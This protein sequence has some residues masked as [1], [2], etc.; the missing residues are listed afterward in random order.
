MLLTSQ[1]I[2]LFAAAVVLC[3]YHAKG[4]TVPAPLAAAP[5]VTL[6]RVF[7]DNMV[8]QEG[9]S[10]PIWGWGQDGDTVTVQFQ[11]ETVSTRV[12]DG[13]WL[14]RLGGLKASGPEILT[15]TT[16]AFSN[17]PAI[18]LTNVLVGEVWLASGQSNMEFPLKSSFAAEGDI[19]KSANPMIHLLHVP[20][21]RL[22]WPTNDISASWT[23]CNPK[24]APDFSAV[25]YY[26]ARD[27]QMALNVPIGVIEAD[28]GATPAEVW[29]QR[30]FL[31]ANPRYKDEVFG[32]WVVAE[33]NYERS[34]A[35]Y[36]K[37]K[38]E[39]K[40]KGMEF[41]NAVPSRPWEP[42]ELF[43]GMIAPLVGYAIKGALWYQGESNAG[44]AE[45]AW[46]YHTLF[47]D[48]IRNWRE[49]WG[50]G[51]FPFLLVQ[52]APFRPIQ[53]AP[54]ESS[55]ASVREAQLR[56]TEVLPNVGMAVI[57]DFGDQHN[58]HP[59]QKEPVGARLAL[60]A[61]GIAYHE[62]IEYS[63]PVLKRVKIEETQIVLTF[64]HVDGGLVANGNE[65]TGFAIC[66]SDKKFAWA[67]AVIKGLDQVLVYSAAVEH[68]IAVRYGWA[69]YPVVNLCNKAGLP[70]SPFR[71][72]DFELQ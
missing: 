36:I 51:P 22:D 50:E 14:V 56:A 71:T 34:L 31:Q 11:K 10:V 58:I 25:E 30:E 15:I 27:L 59:V 17:R 48:L 23:E 60:A 46:Q 61:L 28:W 62:K 35:A 64:D 29:M 21:T 40:A 8:L 39:A 66:G 6:P 26:F 1:K 16:G 43:N 37:A 12:K 70:A 55:W 24:T 42:G 13:R 63:G 69:S 18:V 4:E 9:T 57:T 72:D 32:E 52:L 67:H 49:V 44:S 54:S 7:S 47:P 2:A 53:V 68:P 3:G 19:L 20:R 33:D 38:T 45:E 5:A 65:L 41:T